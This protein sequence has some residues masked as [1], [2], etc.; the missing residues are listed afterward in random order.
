VA[1]PTAEPPTETSGAVIGPYK[2]I[3]LIGEGGM[4]TV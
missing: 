4:G 3:E 2:L 1:A